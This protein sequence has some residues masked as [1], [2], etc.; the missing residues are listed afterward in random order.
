MSKAT[1]FIGLLIFMGL[2]K[3]HCTFIL[4]DCVDLSFSAVD[5][6]RIQDYG[7][8]VHICYQ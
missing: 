1:M 6:G 4:L 7:D 5:K 2:T 8:L 3:C